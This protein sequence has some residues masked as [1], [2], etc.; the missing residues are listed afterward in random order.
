MATKP[1]PQKKAQSSSAESAAHI[2]SLADIRAEQVS[3]ELK[4][5]AGSF[6]D[7]LCS[8]ATENSLTMKCLIFPLNGIV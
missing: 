4:P 1:S 8:G 7:E 5:V 2:R 6:V 3:M